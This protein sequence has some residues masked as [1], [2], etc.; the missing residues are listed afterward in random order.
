VTG[1]EHPVLY[2]AEVAR[3]LRSILWTEGYI[4]IPTPVVREHDC[5]SV[6]RRVRLE[7]GRFL[8]E[9]P[10]HALRRNLAFAPRIFEIAPCMRRD[11]LDESHLQ[12]FTMLDL[13][14]A[15]ASLGDAICLC[16]RLVRTFYKGRLE[17]FSLADHILHDLGIDLVGDSDSESKLLFS[18]KKRYNSDGRELFHLIRRY[19]DDELEER[20]RNL[21]LLVTDYPRAIEAAAKPKVG[22]IA[23]AEIAEFQING[24][25][26]V[27][28]YEDDPDIDAYLSRAHT[29]G[30]Y[31]YEVEIISR[32]VATRE[33]PGQ[34]AGFGIGIERLCQAGLGL[35]SIAPFMISPEFMRE[36][37]E[38]LAL[39]K[40]N[41]S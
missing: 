5:C 24:V 3:R 30:H 29:H 41:T 18:L 9:S 13:Y 15:G 23:I 39:S 11:A 32:L 27:Q 2:M 37:F 7:D 14:C 12:Q 40:C 19:V 20:S 25:E 28:L 36:R 26:I 38:D 22:T 33:V 6:V 31:G 35:D 34:S 21:C 4:E 16:E 1:K 8:R 17:R 10:S